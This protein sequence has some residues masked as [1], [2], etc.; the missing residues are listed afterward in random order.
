MVEIYLETAKPMDI[1]KNQNL[2]RCSSLK[3][4]SAAPKVPQMGISFYQNTVVSPISQHRWWKENF[5][6]IGG[7]RFLENMHFLYFDW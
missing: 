5:L 2:T 7:L 6:L 3:S 1:Q 4:K